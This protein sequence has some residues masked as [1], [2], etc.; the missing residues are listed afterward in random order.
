VPVWRDIGAA[1]FVDGG[2]VFRRVSD[3]ELGDLRGG[4]GFGL[5]YNS[6]MGPLRL[7]LG[8]KLDRR[9]LGGELE[10]RTAL[11]FSFGQAF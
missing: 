3:F 5:R 11:H 10:R 1:V 7:D 6:P 8:F 4:V 2:N 9:E